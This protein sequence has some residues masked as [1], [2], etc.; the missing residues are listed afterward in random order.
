[1][2]LRDSAT[3]VGVLVREHLEAFEKE[4]NHQLRN[5]SA[6]ALN[7][8]T[9]TE[10]KNRRYWGISIPVQVNTATYIHIRDELR[11][12]GWQVL[13]FADDVPDRNTF[14]IAVL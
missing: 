12:V 3:V 5:A 8:R 2:K 9:E 6:A 11:K 10:G 14:K 4:F 13:D 7:S 1:M